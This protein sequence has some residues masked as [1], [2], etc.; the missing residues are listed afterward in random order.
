MSVLNYAGKAHWPLFTRISCFLLAVVTPSVIVCW[1]TL[2]AIL[3]R[4][5]E[6]TT[7]NRNTG[8]DLAT[9][10]TRFIDSAPEVLLMTVAAVGCTLALTHFRM[11]VNR[12]LACG[13]LTVYVLSTYTLLARIS[14]AI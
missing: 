1:M 14:P 5:F 13:H 10:T 12:I 4:S 7:A 2:T 3:S 11:P 8:V 9:D 6:L